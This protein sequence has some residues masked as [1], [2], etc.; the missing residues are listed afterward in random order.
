MPA[1]AGTVSLGGRE[2]SV[3]NDAIDVLLAAYGTFF[4][5]IMSEDRLSNETLH[6]GRDLLRSW[7]A[8]VGATI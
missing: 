6:V 2:E 8:N 3:R 5:S 7:G 1:P 4:D